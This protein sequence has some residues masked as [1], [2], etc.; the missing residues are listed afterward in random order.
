MGNTKA[1][2]INHYLQE[3]G[4][5]MAQACTV[6]TS[7]PGAHTGANLPLS[8]VVALLIERWDYMTPEEQGA[9]INLLTRAN[10]I[11]S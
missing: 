4:Q 5:H 3:T 2:A 7:N 8:Q 11:T 6:P 9:I 10:G 1:I